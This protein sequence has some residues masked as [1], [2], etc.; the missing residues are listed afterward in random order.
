MDLSKKNMDSSLLLLFFNHIPPKWLIV[1]VVWL[2]NER[3]LEALF[4]TE[5]NIR[6]H[7]HRESLTY[8]KQ[9][10]LLCR[11]RSCLWFIRD[12]Q[13]WGSLT[14]F[15]AGNKAKLPSSVNKLCS[16]RPLHHN[17]SSCS[18]L[19]TQFNERKVYKEIRT[20]TRVSLKVQ[21]ARS[22]N[23]VTVEKKGKQYVRQI[24]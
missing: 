2:T 6:D 18:N 5:I 8:R 17:A 24:L 1:F 7:H 19:M 15:P 16:I 3:H 9:L 23:V 22:K 14:M 12:L 13:W 4:P 21:E 10:N 11:F 20:I